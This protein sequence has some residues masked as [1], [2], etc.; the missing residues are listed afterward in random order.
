MSPSPHGRHQ[1]DPGPVGPDSL[2]DRQIA[3]QGLLARLQG[4]DGVAGERILE[5][6]AL[7]YPGSE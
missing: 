1:G 6:P 3:L 5:G 4:L 2:G 7:L